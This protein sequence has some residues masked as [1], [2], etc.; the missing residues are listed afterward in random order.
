[1]AKNKIGGGEIVNRSMAK[2]SLLP[3]SLLK[4][5]KPLGPPP[6]PHQT[7]PVSL[8]RVFFLSFSQ[9]SATVAKADVTSE[10]VGYDTNGLGNN[11]NL[12]AAEFDMVGTEGMDIQKI[13][14]AAGGGDEFYS[15]G[16]QIQTITS[17]MGTEAT[18][19]Y[20]T[21]EDAYEVD[22][23]AEAG[24]FDED[25]TE[26]ASRAFAAGDGFVAVSD[27]DTAYIKLPGINL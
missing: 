16:I 24:W 1:M 18:Y 17:G 22:G 9:Q 23:V 3:Q 21:A 4:P 2:L 11:A 7:R 25:W 12:R 14:P 27:M 20:L 10:I 26:R 19:A 15:G 5:A 6:A 13:K 8:W